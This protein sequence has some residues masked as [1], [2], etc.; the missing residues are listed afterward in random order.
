M[1]IRLLF[2]QMPLYNVQLLDSVNR[3]VLSKVVR[4][5]CRRDSPQKCQHYHSINFMK[6]FTCQ[7]NKK[8][9]IG[10]AFRRPH[11][12]L[13]TVRARAMWHKI[14]ENFPISGPKMLA[15]LVFWAVPM[16]IF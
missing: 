2:I 16:E 1:K 7:K 3:L 14:Y 5:S 6:Y 11:Y 9:A 13:G 4:R 12:Q 15:P 10:K 8:P